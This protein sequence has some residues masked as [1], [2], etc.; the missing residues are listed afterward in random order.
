MQK[1]N[2][3]YVLRYIHIPVPELVSVCR[4]LKSTNIPS[5]KRLAVP[6]QSTRCDW[7]CTTP[8]KFTD[9]YIISLISA[10]KNRTMQIAS[11]VPA[12][13]GLRIFDKFFKAVQ[14]FSLKR[15]SFNRA[16][17]Q[18]PRT[19]L[20]IK[21]TCS[22]N[23]DI[24]VREYQS[25]LTLRQRLHRTR[26]RVKLVRLSLVLTRDLVD[27]VQMESAIWVHL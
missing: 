16:Y 4:L 27:P 8:F 18:W 6:W 21:E 23:L 26:I 9:P 3:A 11:S 24:L 10:Q 5:E 15:R 7:L 14:E 20:H 12:L 2:F 25:L 19:L 1:V 22:P 17:P 13:T